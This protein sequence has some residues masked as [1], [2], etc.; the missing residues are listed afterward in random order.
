VEVLL[1]HAHTLRAEQAGA[2]AHDDAGEVEHE[3]VGREPGDEGS[4]GED[5]DADDEESPAAEQ[6]AGAT[7]GDEEDAEGQRVAREHPLDRGVRGADRALHVG[8]DDVDDRHAQQRH[9]HRHEHHR[10]DLALLGRHHGLRNIT[11]SYCST[12]PKRSGHNRS[13]WCDCSQQ[14]FAT[15]GTDASDGG[16]RMTAEYEMH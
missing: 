2:D 5:A 12:P 6:V 14:Q 9:E 1:D 4:C 3:R 7:G 16:L 13:P 10:E 8:E 15:A 11:H